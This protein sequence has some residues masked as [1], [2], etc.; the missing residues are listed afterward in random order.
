[1]LDLITEIAKL[2]QVAIVLSS[3][4]LPDI[5]HVCAR[6]VV[7]NRGRIVRTG[8]MTDLTQM[9]GRMMEVRVREGH[10]AF[11]EHLRQRD[12]TVQE[13]HDGTL[14]VTHS[15]SVTVEGLYRLASETGHQVRHV[16]PVRQK[17]EEVFLEAIQDTAAQV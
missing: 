1:M 7:I 11:A 9:K 5:E 3:H 6:V 12:F 15:E 8:D 13:T 4:L 17:L 16:S 2:K 10:A 14:I